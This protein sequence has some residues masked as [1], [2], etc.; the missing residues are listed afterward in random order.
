MERP[1]Q[2]KNIKETFSRLNELNERKSLKIIETEYS[3]NDSQIEI[4]KND[5]TFEF[6]INESSFDITKNDYSSIFDTC[7]LV[8]DE[9]EYSFLK[10]SLSS[11]SIGL[12]SE[13]TTGKLTSIIETKSANSDNLYYRLVQKVKDSPKVG[14]LN[15][16]IDLKTDQETSLLYGGGYN[17]II[18]DKIELDT[19]RLDVEKDNFII[20]DSCSCIGFEKFKNTIEA[21]FAAY[22][23]IFGES[24]GI[25]RY[26]CSSES[27]TFE[28][29]NQIIFQTLPETFHIETFPIFNRNIP[30]QKGLIQFPKIVFQNISNYY[31]DNEAF[32]RTLKIIQIALKTRS[33]LGKCVLFSSALETISTVV[34][35]SSYQAKPI[36]DDNYKKSKL[37]QKFK[38]LINESSYLTNNEKA[39]L[40][41]KKINYLNAPTIKD[42]T[43]EAFSIFHI[44]LPESLKKVI[45][46][47]NK[48]L[49]GSIPDEE[50]FGVDMDNLT[51]AYE[52][53]FLVSMLVLK[54]SG[55]SGYVQNKSAITEY[56]AHRKIDISQ[57][58]K[59]KQAIYYKI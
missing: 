3:L 56:H 33:S 25:E 1:F 52:M 32:A 57:K 54:Y 38:K 7:T 30:S 49:H 55:Y 4:W 50:Q 36:N 24:V 9:K 8:G 47:R 26:Y 18:I 53:Q 16:A 22:S 27:S 23:F 6:S 58:V 42:K 59:L 20:I 34:Q 21:Y 46:Y 51:R 12:G 39:F 28:K 14:Y 5:N 11:C 15:G 45:S 41:E 29:T 10:D 2:Y 44:E 19:F 31:L 35:D 17:K 37:R 48:Y 40:I 43:L 13:K